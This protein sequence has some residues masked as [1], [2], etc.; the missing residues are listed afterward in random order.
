[1]NNPCTYMIYN[2]DIDSTGQQ[3]Q[4]SIWFE[5]SNLRVSVT[6]EPTAIVPVLN[7]FIKGLIFF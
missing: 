1:M 3:V 6:L 4:N 5:K 2:L 7:T